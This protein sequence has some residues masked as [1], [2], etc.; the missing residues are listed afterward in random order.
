MADDSKETTSSRHSSTDAH[1]PEETMTAVEDLHK[2]RPDKAPALSRRG[3][4]RDPGLIMGGYLQ[5]I[6]DCK[7]KIS[8]LQWCH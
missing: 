5:L 7:E 8:F 3:R 4:H 6:P 1:K 2:F